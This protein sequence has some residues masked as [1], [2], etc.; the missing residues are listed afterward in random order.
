MN[1]TLQRT[2]KATVGGV[3]LGVGVTLKLTEFGLSAGQVLASGAKN[4]ANEFV[5]GPD[6][7][8]AEPVLKDVE[9]YTGKAAAWLIKK[10][11]S[12]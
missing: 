7:K 5:K 9:K 11:N 4:L 10:G 2:G 3:Y 1:S 8:I 12:Y 6:I